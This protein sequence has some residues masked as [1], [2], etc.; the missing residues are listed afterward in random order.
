MAFN[1]ESLTQED[2]ANARKLELFDFKGEKHTLGSILDTQKKSVV[3]FIRAFLYYSTSKSELITAYFRT[4]LLW[5]KRQT[6]PRV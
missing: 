1:S 5:C 3:V 4:F 2:L 6:L